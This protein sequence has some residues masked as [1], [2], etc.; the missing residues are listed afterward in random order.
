M[1]PFVHVLFCDDVRQEVRGTSSLMGVMSGDI[2]SFAAPGPLTLPRLVVVAFITWNA[3][4]PPSDC[5]FQVESVA[6]EEVLNFAIPPKDD[7]LHRSAANNSL[8]SIT[9]SIEISPLIA[10]HGQSVKAYLK[11]ANRR[12]LIA[13]LKFEA[14]S[15]EEFSNAPVTHVRSVD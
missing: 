12:T 7:D 15:Q 10:K 6:N 3:D 13:S 4:R 14:L 8:I 2:V 9:V 11:Q 1:K 5:S